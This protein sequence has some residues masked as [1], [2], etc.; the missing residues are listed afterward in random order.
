MSILKVNLGSAVEGLFRG[1]G[2]RARGEKGRLVL[3]VAVLKEGKLPPIGAP[4]ITETAEV[5]RR[6]LDPGPLLGRRPG[7]GLLME[8]EGVNIGEGPPEPDDYC[9][10]GVLPVGADAPL[11]SGSQGILRS[12]RD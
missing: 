2:E 1:S 11:Q 7:H 8:R 5:R 3:L 6:H 12:L 4:E 10:A 9:P